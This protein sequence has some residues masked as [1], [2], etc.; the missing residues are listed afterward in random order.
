VSVKIQNKTGGAL[1]VVKKKKPLFKLVPLWLQIILVAS[2]M[3]WAC[4]D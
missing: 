2:L 3:L 4:Q 1:T